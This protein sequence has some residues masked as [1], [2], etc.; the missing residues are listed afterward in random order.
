[1]AIG[2]FLAGLV[3][4]ESE[5]SHQAYAEVRPVRD[6]L[7]GL[8]FITFGMLIDLPMVLERLP[9]VIGVAIAIIVTKAVLATGALMATMTPLRIAV[10]SGIGLAQVGEFSFILGRAS[11]DSGLLR[12]DGGRRSSARALPR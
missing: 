5:F 8:F 7:A 12:Q 11:V 9:L 4:A 6:V 1:M 10:I 3:L 2:A